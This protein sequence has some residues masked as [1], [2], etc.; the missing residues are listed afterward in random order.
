MKIYQDNT[1]QFFELL[2]TQSANTTGAPVEATWWLQPLEYDTRGKAVVGLR[3]NAKEWPRPLA[4]KLVPR[5]LTEFTGSVRDILPTAPAAAEPAHK[6][7][8]KETGADDDKA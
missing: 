2:Y 8:T 6:N 3:R 5:M 1:G 7:K 4:G